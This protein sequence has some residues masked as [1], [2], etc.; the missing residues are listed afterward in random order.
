MKITIIS[1]F[2]EIFP[3]V[4]NSSITL[5]GQRK[6][7]LEYQFINLREFG[8]GA[9]KSVDDKSYGGGVGMVLR[10]DVLAKALKS[11]QIS[12][13]KTKVVLTSPSGNK[14][15][16]VKARELS[17]LD[18]LIIIC[19]HYEGIDQR[20]IDK[21][22]DEEISIGDYILTGGEIPALVIIDA[23]SRLVNGVL[24]SEA[25]EKESFEQDLL[26]HPHYTRPEIFER[27]KVPKTL[28][29]GNHQLIEQWR[30][31]QSLKK[32]KSTRPDLLKKS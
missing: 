8:V 11:I 19:G 13:L 26:E 32:T 22:I 12:K 6:G 16:Q 28:I 27:K 17:V 10:A 18:H 14:L 30:R 31:D 1:L 3:E 15:T 2:P 5:Q 24:K 4:L 9:H 29:S 21:Y 25:T 20:F 23:V 7:F